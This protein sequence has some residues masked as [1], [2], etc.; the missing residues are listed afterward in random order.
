MHEQ[1]KRSVKTGSDELY[2][3]AQYRRCHQKTQE[4]Q[5]DGLNPNS[6]NCK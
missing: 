6:L 4:Y 5:K 1:C 3:H 2:K